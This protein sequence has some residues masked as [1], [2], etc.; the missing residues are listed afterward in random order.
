MGRIMARELKYGGSA[1]LETVVAGVLGK[2][3]YTGDGL[4]T[5]RDRLPGSGEKE[6]KS[7]HV[8][9]FTVCVPLTIGGPRLS[10]SACGMWFIL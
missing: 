2:V 1:S 4:G 5:F 8:K 3:C 7:K 6:S 10:E 9:V